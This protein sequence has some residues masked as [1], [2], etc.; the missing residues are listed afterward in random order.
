MQ[1]AIEKID[2]IIIY[3]E[4]ENLAVKYQILEIIIG[5]FQLSII[6]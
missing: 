2:N 4:K 5:N 3:L 6:N 1:L